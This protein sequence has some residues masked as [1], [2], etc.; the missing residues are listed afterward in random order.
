[1]DYETYIDIGSL[2]S[3]QKKSYSFNSVSREFLME[4]V[5]AYRAYR[6]IYNEYTNFRDDI[7]DA[8]NGLE[9]VYLGGMGKDSEHL[10]SIMER[11]GFHIESVN[12]GTIKT[13]EGICLSFDGLCFNA[14]EIIP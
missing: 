7:M 1:M 11:S 14:D 4:T 13:T 5:M 6:M 9:C 8:L 12:F 2:V 3:Y 10:V